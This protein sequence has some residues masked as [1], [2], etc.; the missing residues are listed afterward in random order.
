MNRSRKIKQLKP[1]KV[2]HQYKCACVERCHVHLLDKHISKF[3]PEDIF[4][5]K[6]KANVPQDTMT[7]WYSSVAVGRNKLGEMMKTM[8]LEGYVDKAVTDHCLW[9]NQNVPEQ[10][11]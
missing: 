10:C 3:P 4:H 1:N 6:P 5:L 7:P 9:C 11:P 2:V 8:A